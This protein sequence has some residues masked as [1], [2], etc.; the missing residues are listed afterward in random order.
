VL[1]KPRNS[2]QESLFLCKFLPLDAD[3]T[4]NSKTMLNTAE[5][6]DLPWLFSLFEDPL[7]LMP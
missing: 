2:L 6:V 7:R 5:K 3:V 4:A 1:I